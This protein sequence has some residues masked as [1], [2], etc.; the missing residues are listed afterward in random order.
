MGTVFAMVKDNTG[1]PLAEVERLL[2]ADK[3]E[4]RLG[5][6]SILDVKACGKDADRSAGDPGGS[7]VRRIRLWTRVHRGVSCG[8]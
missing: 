6:V 1:M 4:M 8:V 5:A 7:A 3:F 2:D